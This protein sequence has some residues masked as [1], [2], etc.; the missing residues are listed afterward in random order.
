M[1]ELKKGILGT[2]L[3]GGLCQ[4]MESGLSSRYLLPSGSSDVVAWLS[5]ALAVSCPLS[6]LRAR[7]LMV[8]GAGCWG[9]GVLGCSCWHWSYSFGSILGSLWL[10][11]FLML[12]GCVSGLLFSFLCLVSFVGHL[13]H[14]LLWIPSNLELSPKTICHG[15]QVTVFDLEVLESWKLDWILISPRYFV[16]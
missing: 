14:F 10:P 15:F 6:P 13:L 4:A 5:L 3:V 8:Y 16:P 7:V 2:K 1:T 12:F 11:L 9:V